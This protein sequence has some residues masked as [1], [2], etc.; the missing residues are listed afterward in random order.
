ME[1]KRKNEMEMDKEK[2]KE[3]EKNAE[4]KSRRAVR[5]FYDKKLHKKHVLMVQVN[6]LG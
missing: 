1:E 3:N 5:C 6:F 2:K 4:E